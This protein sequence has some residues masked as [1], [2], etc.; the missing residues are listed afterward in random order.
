MSQPTNLRPN[1]CATCIT[2]KPPAAGSTT[3]SSGCVTA[4]ISRAIKP[5]GFACGWIRRSTF[6][7]HRSRNAVI[8]PSRFRAQRRPLQHEQII[9]APPS[10]IAIT[11]AQVVPG[12]QIDTWEDIGD[13]EVITLAESK[14][15]GPDKQIATWPQHP[16]YLSAARVD[17]AV[18][19]RR[20]CTARTLTGSLVAVF[21]PIEHAAVLW[22][23]E[24]GRR[25]VI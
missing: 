22:I 6:S 16:R 25:T 10:T 14:R 21:Q 8:T 9:A 1:S 4:A 7:A 5:A 11:R 23:E 13:T 2:V 12:D 24:R 18:T 3:R 20:Q 15:V 19:H 17:I